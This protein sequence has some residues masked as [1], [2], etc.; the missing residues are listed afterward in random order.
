MR[1]LWILLLGVATQAGALEFPATRSGQAA[2][3][4]FEAF[5]AGPEALHSWVEHWRDRE[6]LARTS[7]DDRVARFGQVQEMFGG[8]TAYRILEQDERRTVVLA[9]TE[10]GAGWFQLSWESQAEIPFKISSMAF[11]PAA[12]PE[13]A[14][15]AFGEWTTFAE[16]LQNARDAANA[17]ALAAAVVVGREI[18][19]A[20]AVGVCS[21]RS[22]EAVIAEDAFHIGS[23]TKSFTALLLAHHVECGR[24][25]WERNLGE[26]LPDVEM[27]DAYRAVTISELLRHRGGIPPYT[28]VS[29]EEEL[30]LQALGDEP[31]QARAAF[32]RRVLRE[33]PSGVPGGAMNYSNAGFAILGHI[34]ELID[35]NS[36][37]VQIQQVIFDPLKMS[38]A[39]FGWPP[40]VLG[41]G[42]AQGAHEPD[43]PYRVG[44]YLAPAGDIHCSAGDLARYA[45]EMMKLMQGRG[46]ILSAPTAAALFQVGAY[47]DANYASGWVHELD[48]DGK[49]MFWHNGSAGTFYSLLR[50]HPM[51]ERAVVVL[52]SS[53]SPAAQSVSSALAAELL[54]AEQP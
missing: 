24:L 9:Q 12:P 44:S 34:C 23:I 27:K 40:R 46:G 29:D 7:V 26:L 45:A 6:S 50:I 1:I 42:R 43:D 31:R 41:H 16:L 54:D 2:Q 36:Y 30:E 35:E 20:D 47:E 51:D 39:G 18:V 22:D 3:A 11:A 32:V 8:L 49:P 21:E 15:P 25:D 13:D 53:A 19:E 17:P 37:E 4:W 14:D 5:A 48:E 52:L 28:Y 10:D 38:T 33:D